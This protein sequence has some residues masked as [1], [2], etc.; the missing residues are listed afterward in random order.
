MGSS[1]IR[2]ALDAYFTKSDIVSVRIICRDGITFSGLY[3]DKNRLAKIIADMDGDDV[4]GIYYCLNPVREEAYNNYPHETLERG[5]GAKKTDIQCYRY[6]F[7]DIDTVKQV[8]RE[9]AKVP[10]LPTRPTEEEKAAREIVVKG[11]RKIYGDVA[12]REERLASRAV[13]DQVYEYLE[14][15]GVI[16][17][18]ASSGN[19]WY[20]IG[21]LPDLPVTNDTTWLLQRVMFA[22]KSRFSCDA[23][24]I[25]VLPNADRLTRAGGTINRKGVEADT[26]YWRAKLLLAPSDVV[27]IEALHSVAAEAPEV[28][29]TILE[30]EGDDDGFTSD[31]EP[32]MMEDCLTAF[33][34]AGKIGCFWS[35]G[36]DI[37]SLDVCPWEEEHS[38]VA[39]KDT[40]HVSLINGIPGF[41]D[42][43]EHCQCFEDPET[44]KLR[45]R[46]W[47][48]FRFACDPDKSLYK[49]PVE[50]EEFE[51]YDGY[52]ED[53]EDLSNWG[54]TVIAEPVV[55]EPVRNATAQ[56]ET[57][58]EP[59]QEPE[60]E[61]TEPKYK[62]EGHAETSEHELSIITRSAADFKPKKVKWLWYSRMA[63]GRI[64]WITG[65]PD[66]CKSICTVDIAAR[67]STGADWPDGRANTMGPSKVLIASSEDDIEDTII[68]R[69]M[70]AGA[71]LKNVDIL[72]GV[73][74]K[75]KKDKKTK[76]KMLSLSRDIK[77]LVDKIKQSPDIK[78]LILDPVTS[79]FGDIDTNKD[80]EVR[81]LMD[82]LKN[83]CEKSG[84]SIL[85]IIHS[86][87]RS[88][89][90]AMDKVAGARAL[91]ASVRVTWQFNRDV[92]DRKLLHMA[93]VKGKILPDKSGLDYSIEDVEVPIEGDLEKVPHTLWG[94]S[95][96]VTLTINWTQPR[97]GRATAIQN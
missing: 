95:M 75:N 55:E 36:D 38:S 74:V 88:D 78:L 83:S 58:D 10:A 14:S 24:K 53:I 11:L 90:D 33:Q 93:N 49:F 3:R 59:E 80:K 84:L 40:V 26:P 45:K 4:T 21:R 43:R 50:R 23:A 16:C 66:C 12:T 54:K 63:A 2:K 9:I 17:G 96:R 39:G 5:H 22:V 35:D 31:V 30:D 97:T 18:G 62:F 56:A 28:Q 94:R 65:K 87:K 13:R 89:V 61:T 77:A 76:K 72:I 7:L 57:E 68:P 79:Y 71:E 34:D 67:V 92:E 42:L 81:P 60:P 82:A 91:G 32:F 1:E 41:N 46:T 86:S 85:G 20:L 8:D 15:K 70:A 37:W 29:V 48:D 69:L 25:D 27:P 6:L 44:G 64:T 19:G 73:A 52:D 47:A 51:D